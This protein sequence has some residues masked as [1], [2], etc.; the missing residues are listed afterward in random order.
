M[1]FGEMKILPAQEVLREDPGCNEFASRAF[2]A[3]KA[4]SPDVKSNPCKHSLMQSVGISQINS[5]F[6]KKD[7]GLISE[8]KC[9]GV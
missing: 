1:W 8:S 5:I 6:A 4:F 2:A 3:F 9:G 7:Y